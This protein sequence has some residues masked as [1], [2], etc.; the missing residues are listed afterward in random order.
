MSNRE[1]AKFR[2]SRCPVTNS[3]S[4]N[5]VASFDQYHISYN[6]S[7]ACYGCDTT[8][9][10]LRDTVFLVLKGEH[11]KPLAEAPDLLG[12]MEYFIANIHLAHSFGEHLRITGLDVDPFKLTPTAVEVL[13]VETLDR[14]KQA[15][16]V[17]SG[18][19]NE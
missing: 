7:Y 10:V 13:G 4:P 8:A 5:S 6:P 3:V 18:E 17:I 11:R 12:C 16:I 9:I 15:I 19:D 1:P 2:S 14:L